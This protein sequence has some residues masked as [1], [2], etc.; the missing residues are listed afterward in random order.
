MTPEQIRAARGML[1]WAQPDLAR[2]A[3]VSPSTVKNLENGMTPRR[4]IASAIER[5]FLAAGVKFTPNGV[6][7]ISDQPE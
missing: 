5:A 2:A 3:E 7:R 1:N 4:A 6:E